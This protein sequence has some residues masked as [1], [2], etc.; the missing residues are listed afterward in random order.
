MIRNDSDKKTVLV[1]SATGK[2]LPYKVSP[3]CGLLGPGASVPVTLTP[4]GETAGPARGVV[5]IRYIKSDP[6]P[7]AHSREQA[8]C[9]I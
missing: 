6:L 4:T 1:L 5:R 8:F 7:L 9:A 2:G 3:V